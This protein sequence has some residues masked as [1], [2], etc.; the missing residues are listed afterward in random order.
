MNLGASPPWEARDLGS[1]RGSA[2]RQLDDFG[3][4]AALS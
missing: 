1:S 3:Q 4:I 2:T